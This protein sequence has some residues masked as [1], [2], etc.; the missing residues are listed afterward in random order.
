MVLDALPIN[1]SSMDWIPSQRALEIQLL[2]AC[3]KPKAPLEEIQRLCQRSLDWP[4]VL[5]LA[6]RHGVMP[7][8]F[9]RLKAVKF[10]DVNAAIWELLS[11]QFKTNAQRSLGLTAHLIKLIKLFKTENIPVF[12]FKGATLAQLAYQDL[13]SRQFVDL[14]L[15]I[16]EAEVESAKQLLIRAGYLPQL[17]LTPPQQAK[18]SH[19]FYAL[20]FIHQT[21]HIQV[22]LHW[23]ILR[24]YFSFCPPPS[25]L[26]QSLTAIDLAGQ[27]VPTLAP[28]CLL[29]FICAHSAKDN[30]WQL[31]FLVDQ[32]WLVAQH[33]DLDWQWIDQHA[34]QLGTRRMLGLGLYLIQ[35]LLNVDLPKVAVDRINADPEISKLAAFVLE[36]LFQPGNYEPD[37][38]FVPQLYLQSMDNWQDRLWFWIDVLTT[39]TRAEW[40]ILALPTALTFLYYPFRLLRLTGKY[41]LKIAG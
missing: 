1:S 39:P 2:L 35:N 25:L 41:A 24:Q 12:T 7:L 8:L 19:Q 34:G 22:D 10:Q 16:L 29:L 40:Q 15:F 13:A 14:D 38:F 36:Q 21:T 28:E 20:T 9:R 4:Y 37:R 11:Q 23:A 33:P 32:A 3:V 27:E 17:N 30:W 31:R 6:S 26:R 5:N 18:Y